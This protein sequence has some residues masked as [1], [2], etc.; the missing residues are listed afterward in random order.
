MAD[1]NRYD[2]VDR[3]SCNLNVR[4]PTFVVKQ[5]RDGVSLIKSEIH[6]I[7]DIDLKCLV[8]AAVAASF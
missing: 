2:G 3:G 4:L 1:S 6:V 8:D 7:A 5:R